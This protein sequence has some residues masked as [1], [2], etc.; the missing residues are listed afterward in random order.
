MSLSTL[1]YLTT[2]LLGLSRAEIPGTPD[3]SLGLQQ[4]LREAHQG[5]LYDY[6]T[7]L[8]QGIVPKGI[9]S[10]NDYWR[11]VPFYSALSVGVISTE[12]DVWLYNGTLHIGHEESALTN[13]RTFE[14]LYINPILSVLQRQN[15]ANSSFVTSKTYNGVFDTSGG[16]TLY[17]FVD[18]KTDGEETWPYVVKALEP[19]RSA[20]YLSSTNGSTFTSK[21]VTVIGTGNTPLNLVQPIA[22]RDYFWDGPIPTLNSTFSNITSLVSPIASADFAAVFGNV[23]G[24]S[25]NDT[26]LALLRAQVKTAHD[27]GIMLRYWDQPGW[28]LSTRNGL[29]RQLR[30]EGVDLINADD[31]EAA[32]GFGDEW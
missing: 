11:D 32:A 24:T 30:S 23:I 21:P 31:I 6:P 1:L 7:S 4:I 2:A 25:L 16:Q 19:L 28:P 13:A 9:H 18:V 22:S 20:G 15:P 5:P 17:L 10:H 29:W 26:Q 14:S 27:K 3:L 8:T 12:A